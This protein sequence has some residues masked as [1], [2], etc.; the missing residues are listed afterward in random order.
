LVTRRG[1]VVAQFDN[2][3]MTMRLHKGILKCKKYM[4]R[5]NFLCGEKDLFVC[6]YFLNRIGETDAGV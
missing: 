3:I 2:I 5:E 6:V 1:L 4:C